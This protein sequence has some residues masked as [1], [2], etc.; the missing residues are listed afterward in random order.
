MSGPS[1]SRLEKDKM[2][3]RNFLS[4]FE[5]CV[6]DMKIKANKLNYLKSSLSDRALQLI[7]HFTI[8]SRNYRLLKKEFMVTEEVIFNLFQQILGYISKREKTY[9]DWSSFIARTQ[10]II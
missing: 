4:Q 5:N 2:N 6:T 9:S 7:N 1:F 3:Y 8:T 10:S